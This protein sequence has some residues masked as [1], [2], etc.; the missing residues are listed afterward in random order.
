VIDEALLLEPCDLSD[1]IKRAILIKQTAV[2]RAATL[3][4]ILEI[5]PAADKK[6]IKRN[7]FKLSKDY[8]P[9]RYYGKKLGSFQA[10]LAEIFEQM[11]K[12]FDILGDDVKREQ[13]EAELASRGS[14]G[15][16]AVPT[17]SV[18]RATSPTPVPTAQIKAIA[19]SL[20][21]QA[22]HHQVTGELKTA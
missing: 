14:P 1:E 3:Y 19:S 22:I 21:E 10:R 16:G 7:Y 12:A 15:A 13:Y 11:A 2:K 18:A 4:D 17:V 8:H 6:T 9:D 20:F 5:E